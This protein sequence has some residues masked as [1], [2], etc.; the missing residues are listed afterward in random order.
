[1]PWIR[2]QAWQMLGLPRAKPKDWT[3]QSYVHQAII[4]ESVSPQLAVPLPT[5]AGVSSWRICYRAIPTS[6][7][8]T[9]TV[10]RGPEA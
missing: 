1:M 5:F 2:P 9:F 7:G 3:N 8:N 6:S 4:A 10:D